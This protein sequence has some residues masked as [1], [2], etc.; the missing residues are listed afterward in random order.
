MLPPDVNKSMHQYTI[1]EDGDILY[2]FDSIKGI[3]QNGIN[4]II[5]KRPFEH[6]AQLIDRSQKKN[7]NKKNIKVLALSGAVDSIASTVGNRMQI[8]EL[9]YKMRGDKED[10]SEELAAF[11]KRKLL[12]LEKEYLGVYVSGHPLEGIS[13]PV[14]WEEAEKDRETITAHAML[15]DIRRITTKKGDP[16]A[17]VVLQFL[18]KD[19]PDIPLF[20]HL[21]SRMVAFRKGDPEVPLGDLLKENMILK[22]SGKF[23]EN[24]RDELQFMLKQVT[25]PV[26]VNMDKSHEIKALQE[27]IGVEREE[28]P[29]VQAPAFDMQEIFS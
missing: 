28:E 11:N 26:K 29:A 3:S 22:V 15:S 2:G 16:M 9:L 8:L 27:E 6:V 24:N 17:F 25:I 1:T 20:P 14:D 10:L 13:R 7:L 19:I 4:E 5:E 18:E 23:E 12:E 21:Y